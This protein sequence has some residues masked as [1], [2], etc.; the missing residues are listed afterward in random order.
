MRSDY[1]SDNG[2]AAISLTD[3][4][5]VV[6]HTHTNIPR[7]TYLRYARDRG[8]HMIFVYYNNPHEYNN[9]F[10]YTYTRNTAVAVTVVMNP[11]IF[12]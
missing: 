10:Y 5:I 4:K 11:N 12:G 3:S 9:I 2:P 1:T 7:R 6:A 8:L